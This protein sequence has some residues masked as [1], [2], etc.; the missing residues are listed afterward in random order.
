MQVP[1]TAHHSN[2][3]QL[4][5]EIL[6]LQQPLTS[7]VERL[8]ILALRRQTGTTVRATLR[9]RYRIATTHECESRKLFTDV[10]VFLAVEL[11]KREENT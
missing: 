9:D 1:D 5:H 7:I 4:L 11:L 10:N 6:Q 3:V 8:Q 2:H